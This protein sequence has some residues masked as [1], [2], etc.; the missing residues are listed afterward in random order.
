MRRIT[1]DIQP[2]DDKVQLWIFKALEGR[3]KKEVFVGHEFAKEYPDLVWNEAEKSLEEFLR[4]S[5]KDF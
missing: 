4:K 1:V 3:A 2:Y 5:Q